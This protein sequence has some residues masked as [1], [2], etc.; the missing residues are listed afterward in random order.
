MTI[1][2]LG[3]FDI[4]YSS[5]NHHRKSLETLGHKVITLQEGVATSEQI[6]ELASKSELFI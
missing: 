1:V 6:L 3:N 4:E 5:E 2:F